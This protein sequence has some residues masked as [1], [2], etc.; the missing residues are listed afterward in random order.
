VSRRCTICD[1]PECQAI[2]R[3]LIEGTAKRR[4]A[5]QFGVSEAAVRRHEKAG[6]VSAAMA[7]ARDAADAAHGDDLLAQCR[8]LQDKALG[9]LS[10]AERA[11]DLRTAIAAIREGRS[12]LELLARLLAELPAGAAVSV[13]TSPDWTQTLTVLLA[14]LEPF[15]DARLAVA[16]RL[17]ELNP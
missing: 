8:E 6:H 7:K 1:H 15:P 11:G 2:D 4:I 10:K 3:A 14:A 17:A 12:C 13:F 5:S 16:D 9:I